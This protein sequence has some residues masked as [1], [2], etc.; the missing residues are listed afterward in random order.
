MPH[1]HSHD[2]SALGDRGLIA[3]MALNLLLTLV[4][5]LAGVFSG[6]L[7]LVADAVH[8]FND[9]A[10]LLVALVAR[11]I[12]RR[13]SDARRTFG[14]R[15]AETLGAL[16]NLLALVVIGVYLAYQAVY[17]LFSPQEIHGWTVVVVAAIAL[18][19]DV[20]TAAVLFAGSR[21]NLNLRAAFIHNVGDALSS[22][23]VIVAGAAVLFFDATWLDAVVTLAIAGYLMWQSLPMIGRSAHILLESVP[24]D[25]ALEELIADLHSVNGVVEVHHVHVWEMDEHHRALEAHVVVADGRL[26][27]W[28]EIKGSLKLRL[29]DRYDIHH[30]TL[31][32]ET[33]DEAAC[34]VC[35]PAN[36]RE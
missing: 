25:I 26:A 5:A 6:S 30:S 10:S 13:P 27:D 8:N 19:I 17:R 15:R 36:G 29:R 9:C 14:Y 11:R 24:T 3:A 4:E 34:D 16:V 35:P 21:E 22:L 32:F 2:H 1:N 23:G 28:A 31:E 18:V 7:A 12:G 33:I 20:A